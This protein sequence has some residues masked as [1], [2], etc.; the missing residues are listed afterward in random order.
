MDSDRDTFS[1]Q[2]IGARHSPDDQTEKGLA[3][4]VLEDTAYRDDRSTPG[5]L[6]PVD[7]VNDDERSPGAFRVGRTYLDAAESSELEDE[8]ENEPDPRQGYCVAVPG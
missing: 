2:G 1:A 3:D 8:Y 4:A 7:S 6:R 5:S